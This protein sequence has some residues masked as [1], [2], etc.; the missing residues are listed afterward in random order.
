MSIIVIRIFLANL[1]SCKTQKRD[2]G[3]ERDGI[4]VHITHTPKHKTP[5]PRWAGG[6]GVCRRSGGRS[7]PSPL[8]AGRTES[9]RASK[10]TTP[11]IPVAV[12][13]VDKRARP[14]QAAKLMNVSPRQVAA[15]KAIEKARYATGA[16]GSVAFRGFALAASDGRNK[17]KTF[18]QTSFY[19]AVFWIHRRAYFFRS[20]PPSA[21]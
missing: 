1:T 2:K 13:R 12:R 7:M 20:H 3:Q 14:R 17:P 16:G 18:V 4:S 11:S 6:A 5:S 10:P 9:R 15:A 21:V 8:R 19:C